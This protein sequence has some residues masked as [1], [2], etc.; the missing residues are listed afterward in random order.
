MS[1]LERHI[2][3]SRRAANTHFDF[4][5]VYNSTLKTTA[6]D[7]QNLF[8]RVAIGFVTDLDAAPGDFTFIGPT[9]L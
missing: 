8:R 9:K 3:Y 4:E 7:R 5:L 6:C 2:I 1:F